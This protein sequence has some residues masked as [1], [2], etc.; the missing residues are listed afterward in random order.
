MP[1]DVHA[2]SGKPLAP[3]A[4]IAPILTQAMPPV[5]P[6]ASSL[7][8]A[9]PTL[10]AATV[11]CPRCGGGALRML[12]S[13]ALGC[14]GCA[15]VFQS[16]APAPPRV[17]EPPPAEALDQIDAINAMLR[18]NTLVLGPGGVPLAESREDERRGSRRRAANQ[19]RARR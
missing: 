11:S 7:P 9:E 2:W 13:G 12:A 10:A 16:Q 1:R 5:V 15:A 17:A 6:K 14:S 3:P 4:P 18:R 19:R 8:A